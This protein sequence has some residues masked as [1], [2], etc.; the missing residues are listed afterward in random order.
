MALPAVVVLM[1]LLVW[2]V[3]VAAAQLR[4]IDA[5]GLAARAAARGEHDPV[6][7]ALAVA[8]AGAAVDVV[9]SGDTVRVLVEAQCP[10]LGGL[11]SGMSMKVSAVAVAANEAALGRE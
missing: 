4:C 6:G 1:V 11:A 2:G 8:P 7:R 9:E 5:A 3:L 10:G